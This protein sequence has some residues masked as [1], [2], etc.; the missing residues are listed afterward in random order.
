MRPVLEEGTVPVR[1]GAVVARLVLEVGRRAVLAGRGVL[2]PVSAEAAV[3]VADA[4]VPAVGVPLRHLERVAAVDAGRVRECLRLERAEVVVLVDRRVLERIGEALVLVVDVE[5]EDLAERSFVAENH[6]VLV[7][8]GEIRRDLL[9]ARGAAELLADEGAVVP[10]EVRLVLAD[11]IRRERPDGVLLVEALVLAVVRVDLVSLEELGVPDDAD[12]RL[13]LVAPAEGHEVVA[14]RLRRRGG[15]GRTADHPR[16]A[17]LG[18]VVV[19]EEDSDGRRDPL[20]GDRVLQE[21]G[22]GP[23]LAELLRLVVV[24]A[25]A[26]GRDAAECRVDQR[27]PPVRVSGE[28][29]VDELGAAADLDLVLR[30]APVEE[31]ARDELQLVTIVLLARVGVGVHARVPAVAGRVRVGAVCPEVRRLRE[32]ARPCRQDVLGLD[33]RPVGRV[34][35]LELD[36]RVLPGEPVHREVRDGVRGVRIPGGAGRVVA[37]VE[38]VRRVV[39]QAAVARVDQPVLARVGRHLAEVVPGGALRVGLGRRD[40]ADR[41]RLAARRR[42]R[43]TGRRR[44]RRAC[45]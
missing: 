19:V 30:L 17:D 44:S 9:A 16:V 25:G 40:A 27:P 32:R 37:R 28:V 5:G 13:D 31:L 33:R 24:V 41:R 15:P 18:E 38:P 22:V 8:R 4:R 42:R 26:D 36:E 35:V 23:G 11:A 39:R 14:G 1:L 34:D 12:A 20:P 7:G 43:R 21:G 2:V 6:L 29:E 10:P 3:G 45:P